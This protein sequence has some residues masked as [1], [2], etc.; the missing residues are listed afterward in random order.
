VNSSFDKFGRIEDHYKKD[1]DNWVCNLYF[2]VERI[3][4][5]EIKTHSV[6]RELYYNFKKQT[7]T[8]TLNNGGSDKQM[9]KSFDS[10]EV[11]AKGGGVGFK[12]VTKTTEINN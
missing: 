3:K 6:T 2:E 10:G 7:S 9:V 5:S 1:I 11:G 4:L 8:A 12:G